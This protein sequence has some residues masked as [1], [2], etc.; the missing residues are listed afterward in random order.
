M[1]F[2]SPARAASGL[3]LSLGAD[4]FPTARWASQVPRLIYSRALPPTT[5]ESPAGA[6]LLLPCRFQASSWS[7]DWPLPYSYR[8]RIGFTCV[9]ARVFAP[10]R[11]RQNGLL[12]LTLEGYMSE[13]AIYMVN[14]FQ[15]TRSARLILVTDRQEAIRKKH[16]ASPSRSPS[17]AWPPHS[18]PG[19]ARFS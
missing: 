18:S 3:C 7:A 2:R 16:G 19:S 10:A 8:G 14:S 1:L 11:L 12:H 15:F 4:C 9:A 5:P 6:C 17:S 13:Q